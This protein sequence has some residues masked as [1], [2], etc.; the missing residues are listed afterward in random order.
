MLVRNLSYACTCDDLGNFFSPCG[1]IDQ[2]T[3]PLDRTTN[4]LRGYGFVKFKKREDAERAMEKY[5]YIYKKR[6]F[7]N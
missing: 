7:N 1:E 2:I 5:I 3:I 4:K 6:I